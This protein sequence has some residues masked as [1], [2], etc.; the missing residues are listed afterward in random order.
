V[1]LA[2]LATSGEFDALSS[3]INFG[4]TN[5]ISNTRTTGTGL[6]NNDAWAARA[7]NPLATHFFEHKVTFNGATYFYNTNDVNLFLKSTSSSLAFVQIRARIVADIQDI[8]GVME[9]DG[10]GDTPTVVN[11]WTVVGRLVGVTTA[12]P[13]AVLA[14]IIPQ[15]QLGDPPAGHNWGIKAE[16]GT[17][18][19]IN[20][21][22]QAF[23]EQEEVGFVSISS[24][25]IADFTA[26]PTL[27]AGPLSVQFTNTTIESNCGPTATYSWK[28]R[29]SGSGDAF[30]EFSTSENPQESFTK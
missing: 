30:V 3:S 5:L 27:G 24:L 2:V 29:I 15:V 11:V 8:Q 20:T 13:K 23:G 10:G 9:I 7:D 1:T 6:T 22:T 18:T 12:N 21:A 16:A 25:P 19:Y 14:R 26:V 17:R 4:P 28:K